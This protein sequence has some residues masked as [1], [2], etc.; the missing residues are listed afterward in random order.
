MGTNRTVLVVDDDPEFRRT[1]GEILASHGWEV[2]H[3]SEGEQGL[4]LA[5]KHLPDLILCDLLMPRCNGFHFCRALRADPQCAHTR[6]VVTSGRTF[7]ADQQEAFEAG[8]NDYF[9]KPVSATELASYL[10]KLNAYKPA[11]PENPNP[12]QPNA[13]TMVA[14][15]WGVRGSIPTPGSGTVQ[16]GGNTTCVEVRVGDQLIILDAGTGLRPLGLSLVTEFGKRPINTTLLITHTHWDHIQGLP[17]FMPLYQANNHLHVVGFEGA[18]HGLEKVLS[19]Q[20]ESPFFPISFHQLPGNIEIE[21]L[22][23]M[24]FPLGEAQVSA[25]FANHPGICVGY[26]IASA[27][28]SLAFF[29][30][31]ETRCIGDT[32]HDPGMLAFLKGVDAL[33]MDAQYDR[34]EYKSHVGWGHGCVDA[35]VSLAA[36]AGVKRLYLFHHDPDH[37]DAKVA[38]MEAYAQDLAKQM[39][40]PLQVLAAREGMTVRFPASAG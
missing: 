15:F 27:S 40:S 17:F 20:M 6:I 36:T 5:R 29:P 35:V 34:E 24:E 38:Q 28:G 26:R 10:E 18:R 21:E 32:Q 9:T 4:E 13:S 14:R 23:H 22:K 16:V 3:A 1:M 39:N 25:A 30:D 11:A 2:L 7:A 31:N 12:S 33:I 8:A 37:D 19:R